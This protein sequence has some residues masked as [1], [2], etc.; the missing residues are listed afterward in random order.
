MHWKHVLQAFNF[1]DQSVF[2]N[3]IESIATVQLH[4]LIFNGQRNL[5]LEAD[6]TEI[7]FVANALFVS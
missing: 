3:Q 4:S 1:Q 2:D 5:S 7:K 6:S